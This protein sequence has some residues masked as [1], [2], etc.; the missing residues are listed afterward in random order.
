MFTLPYTPPWHL[1]DGLVQTF[2]VSSFYGDSFIKTQ[3]QTPWLAPYPAVP[4]QE[5]CFSGADG[6][7][8]WGLWRCP[9][10]ARGTLIITYGITGRVES[11]W[12]AQLLARK[13]YQR[14]WAVVLY[15]W[16]AHGRTALYSPVPS[17]DG[18]REGEDQVRMAEQL[19]A[20]GCPD[21][22]ALAGFSLGGQLALWGLKATH[23]LDSPLIRCAA[24]LAPNLESNRSLDYLQTQWS[25]R[26]IEYVLVQELKREAQLRLERYPA[27]VKPG[28]VE[29]INSIR[30]F[31][32]EMVIDYY[33]FPSTEDYY[34]KT[35]ALY[36]LDTLQRPY[37]IIYAADDPMFTPTLIPDLAERTARNPHAHL[38]LTPQGGHVGHINTPN[39]Q[40]DEFWGLN[41]MLEYCEAMQG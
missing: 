11:A 16:R 39:P 7:P 2:L 30:A 36:L 38:L 6:V 10:G 4:W 15:D 35:S 26:M 9:M 34:Q 37:L 19:V 22:V 32:Q 20:L 28:A 8:I 41:R 17:A 18:W 29:R 31:D 23:D 24:V 33:G 14:G 5:H 12:Y 21:W 3:D 25:G 13:A 1:R 27:A 40:E